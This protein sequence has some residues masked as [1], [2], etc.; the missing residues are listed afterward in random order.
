MRETGSE[1]AAANTRGC[2]WLGGGVRPPRMPKQVQS[3]P[4]PGT[5]G[6]WKDGVS[7]LAEQLESSDAPRA[8]SSYRVVHSRGREGRIDWMLYLGAADV[9]LPA[10]AAGTVARAMAHLPRIC[11]TRPRALCRTSQET[12]RAPGGPTA[13]RPGRGRL[14]RWTP[15]KA[16]SSEGYEHPIL[17]QAW[18][19]GAGPPG[20]IRA[21]CQL[22]DA[23][24]ATFPD[25]AYLRSAGPAS[26][27]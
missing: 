19:L 2:L 12:R 18:T 16:R 9:Y 6:C 10:M 7:P 27:R 11:L 5:G 25:D 15:L 17:P 1:S 13:I 24:G 22:V 20:A 3:S 4:N 26:R 23:G 21:L 8:P 14:S